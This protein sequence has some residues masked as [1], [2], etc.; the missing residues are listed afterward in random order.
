MS[1]GTRKGQF[2][3]IG[4]LFICA[5][6]FFGITPMITITD[7]PTFDMDMISENLRKELPH[8]LNIGINNSSPLET[9]YN[10]TDFSRDAVLSRGVDLD[11]LWVVFTPLD[12]S[13]NVS[14]GNFMDSS[15]II[16]VNVSGTYKDIYVGA[17]AINSSDFS[18]SA[19]T[20]NVTLTIDGEETEATL[21]SNKTSIYSLLSLERGNNVVRKELLA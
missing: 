16:G 1:S 5:L 15:I 17:D 18:V 2:F 12:G 3:M 7:S 10:F 20:F 4:A 21:L 9:L 11:A 8:A 19:Y 14:A 6:L 13:V